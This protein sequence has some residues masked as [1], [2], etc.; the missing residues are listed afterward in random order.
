MSQPYKEEKHIIHLVIFIQIFLCW[1][2]CFNLGFF[3]L[4]PVS[5]LKNTNLKRVIGQICEFEQDHF[6]LKD[7][8]NCSRAG[9]HFF[10]L[11]TLKVSLLQ[12]FRTSGVGVF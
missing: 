7:G 12:I 1:V 6:Q 10:P 8:E 5:F 3:I 9:F 11:Q 2:F 4:M